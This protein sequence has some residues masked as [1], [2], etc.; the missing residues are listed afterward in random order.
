MQQ[1][2]ID[3]Q[4]AQCGYCIAGMVMRAEALLAR[5]PH[6]TEAE[7][8]TPHVDEPVP[9]RHADADRARGAARGRHGDALVKRR[10]FLSA[11][12]ALVVAFAWRT[13]RSQGEAGASGPSRCRRCRAA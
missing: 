4:A 6:P 7:I 5:N 10:A 3:E 12:G 11:G 1:A 9:L 8:R 13:G 2:F